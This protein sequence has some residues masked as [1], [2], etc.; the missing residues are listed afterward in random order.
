MNLEKA[1]YKDGR[2]YVEYI[3]RS[4][5]Q[6]GQFFK[7]YGQIIICKKC[8]KKAFVENV[9][10]ERERGKFCS[11]KCARYY[12]KG[13]NAPAYKNGRKKYLGYIL[14]LM[15]KHPN[16]T[17]GYVR[18]HRLVIEKQIG[19]YLHRCEAIHHINRIKDDNYP[20]NLMAFKNQGI[21]RRFERGYPI[22]PKDIIFDG[23]KLCKKGEGK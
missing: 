22:N 17:K 21:H 7:C 16:A 2:V 9:N 20:E 15:P 10:I 8:G 5:R 1:R 23:R 11:L 14:V 19:R 13:E 4:G 12:R 3:H 6:K 18:E